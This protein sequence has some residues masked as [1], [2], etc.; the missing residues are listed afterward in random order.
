MEQGDNGSSHL[1]VLHG[2][3]DDEPG[4]SPER[5][6][7]DDGREERSGNAGPERRRK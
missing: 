3:D 1:D 5:G 4:D 6:K 7:D 2:A